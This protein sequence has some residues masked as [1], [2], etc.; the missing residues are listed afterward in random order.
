METK[1]PLSLPQI[2]RRLAELYRER[3]ALLEGFVPESEVGRRLGITRQAMH[4][5]S[6]VS[7]REMGGVRTPDGWWYRED[8]LA[9]HDIRLRPGRRPKASAGKSAPFPL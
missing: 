6:E 9:K 5:R 1:P 2:E 7:K 4:K 8:T 3:D